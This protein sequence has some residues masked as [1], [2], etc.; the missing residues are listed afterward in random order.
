MKRI[1][2][3]VFIFVF[4]MNFANL[5]FADESSY[6]AEMQKLVGLK[7]QN[8]ITDKEFELKK[9]EIKNRFFCNLSANSSHANVVFL[10]DTKQSVKSKLGSPS[11]F[12]GAYYWKYSPSEVIY[13]DQNDKVKEIVGFS[14]VTIETGPIDDAINHGVKL[15]NSG[16]YSEALKLFETLANRQPNRAIIQYNLGTIYLKLGNKKQ[17]TLHFEQALESE[18]SYFKGDEPISKTLQNKIVKINRAN[19]IKALLEQEQELREQIDKLWVLSN[20]FVLPE[21]SKRKLEEE[22]SELIKKMSKIRLER[23]QLESQQ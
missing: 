17:S 7:K 13:F 5:S 22:E 1:L 12:E 16:A 14:F 11:I 4:L 18:P 15:V 20:A 10:G 21:R 9:N 8:K 19:K 2:S 23:K 6:L 3:L